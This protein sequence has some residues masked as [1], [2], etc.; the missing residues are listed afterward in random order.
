[1]DTDQIMRLLWLLLL[2]AVLGGWFM[3]QMRRRPGQ[4]LQHLAVWGL[5]F[6]GVVASYGLWQDIRSELRPAQALMANGSIE[7]P[8]GRD[9]HFHAVVT[10][11][12]V[13]VSFVVDTGASEIVLTAK[14]AARVGIDPQA[15]AY[16][17]Q[18]RTANGV[19]R[20][21][22]VRLRSVALGPFEM[23]DVRAV[24]NEGD[25]DGSLLGMSWITQFARVEIERDRLTLTP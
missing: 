4:S 20:T 17:G 12:D 21:A 2:V 15:L 25:M 7:I 1:M 14:D 11:N 24:V 22:P 3:L 16:I 6:A 18:A 5:I 10:I 9:G 23:T 19:V 13:P 8:L